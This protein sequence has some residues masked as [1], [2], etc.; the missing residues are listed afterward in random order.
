MIKSIFYKEDAAEKMMQDDA[1]INSIALRRGRFMHFLFSGETCEKHMFYKKEP[2]EKT[3]QNDARIN[4]IAL[5][6]GLFMH[7]LFLIKHM[8][9]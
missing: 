9:T 6:R 4:S 3:M 7:F 1:I 8:S 5:R 2:P